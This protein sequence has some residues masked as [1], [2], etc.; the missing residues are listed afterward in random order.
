MKKRGIHLML[1]YLSLWIVAFVYF[2]FRFSRR[3]NSLSEAV[4]FFFEIATN[5]FLLI[6]FH[7][8]FM[9]VC[10]LYFVI[11]HFRKV[12]KKKGN[13][14]AWKQF[15][16]KFILPVLF[17]IVGFKTLVYINANE[18]HDYDWDHSAMN[19]SGQV[20]HLYE[21]DEKHRGASVF[22]WSEDNSEAIDH[23]IKANV[24][25]VAVIPFLYQK[26]ENTSQM[27]VPSSMES[28]SRRD[29]SFVRAINDL[30]KNG[31]RVHLK[32]HLWMRE[33]WRSNI[34]LKDKIEWDQWFE[35]YRLNMLRYAKIAQRTN[36]E[37]FCIGTELRTSIKNQPEKWEQLIKE[38]RAIYN[39]KLTYAANW[40]D[41]YEHVT[42]W[43]QLDFIGIQAYFP[44][45]KEEHPDLE[46][47]EKGWDKHITELEG[48]H[49]KY[50]KPILF[51]EVGYK[52]TP[53]ATIKPWE[54]SSY[55]NK[56][57]V[58]KSDRTQQLA[59]EAMF[60]KN[61]NQPWFAGIYIWEWQNRTTAESAMTDLD[62]SPRFKPAENVI[63]KW[64]G[65][66]AE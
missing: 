4:S 25:W 66:R 27:D 9:L 60:K 62:F 31:L 33:G 64:F 40:Y 17:I 19:D 56:L 20:N 13:G 61:W 18:W 41:E 24:E 5:T 38:V 6:G 22:G 14:M 54:W 1:L 45:T 37:L 47:I 7:V 34:K 35:S 48:V 15:S 51:T 65:K 21:I 30:H 29:S 12:A 3:N 23:L 44:L 32:P 8:I 39:G 63:A 59:Y 43:E 11:Y 49:K 36:T 10:L 28:Y 16:I 57:T 2:L 26:D 53:D 52:S 55:F 58:K 42:F 46:S 50:N